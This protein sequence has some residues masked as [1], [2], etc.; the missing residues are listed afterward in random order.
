MQTQIRTFR[1]MSTSSVGTPSNDEDSSAFDLLTDEVVAHVL[2]FVPPLDLLRSS[3]R[4]C[5]RFALL[6]REDAFWRTSLQC[7][8]RF[9]NKHSGDRLTIHQLQRYALYDAAMAAEDEQDVGW[10]LLQRGSL[11]PTVETALELKRTGRSVCAA[12]ST[13]R[14][15][16]GLENVLTSLRAPSLFHRFLKTWWSSTATVEPDVRNEV[17]MFATQYRTCL[18]TEVLIQPLRDPYIGHVCYSWKFTKIRVRYN[19][20]TFVPETIVENRWLYTYSRYV[21]ALSGVLVAA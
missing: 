17:L 3:C 5:A 6:L 4:T 18:M 19:R 20:T 8:E 7:N 16:E 2:S 11:L 13:D 10:N 15:S 21:C 12:S 9:T 14:A 1:T